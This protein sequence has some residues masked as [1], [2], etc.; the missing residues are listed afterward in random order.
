MDRRWITGC[1]GFT[2]DHEKGV[3]DFL[4]FLRTRY[5]EDEDIICPCHPC[6]NNSIGTIERIGVHLHV[7]GMA[8]TYTRWIHHGEA[9]EYMV[10]DDANVHYNTILLDAEGYVDNAAPRDGGDRESV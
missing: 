6:L 5:T 2:T 7:S 10:D 8:T 9:L 1:I 3:Q 4:A